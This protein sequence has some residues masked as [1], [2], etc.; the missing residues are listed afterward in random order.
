MQSGY[1]NI[2]AE[3]AELIAISGDTPAGVARTQ[4]DLGIAFTLLS[5][6]NLQ[7]ITDYNIVDQIYANIGRPATYI[8]DENG[9]IAWKHLGERFGHRT[10]SSEIIAGLQ[11][12]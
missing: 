7:T 10:T 1:N 4:D 5:D 11:G 12:L 2:K 9:K 3:G 8:V 6:A